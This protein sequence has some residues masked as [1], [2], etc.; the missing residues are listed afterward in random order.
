MNYTEAL[1]QAQAEILCDPA[2]IEEALAEL[3]AFTG[4][5][6]RGG[7]NCPKEWD[8]FSLNDLRDADGEFDYNAPAGALLVG[9]FAGDNAIALKCRNVLHE[10]M[11][12]QITE[13]AE[14]ELDLMLE[15]A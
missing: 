15:P 6:P 11:L 4:K 7:I 14:A 5:N 13:K 2:N 9:L 1:G 3:G 10:R 8:T 12:G